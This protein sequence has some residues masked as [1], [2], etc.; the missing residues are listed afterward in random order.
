[1]RPRSTGVRPRSTSVRPR[2]TSVRPRSTGNRTGRARPARP[3]RRGWQARRAGGGRRCGPRRCRRSGRRRRTGRCRHLTGRAARDQPRST[4]S[5]R[6][7]TLCCRPRRGRRARRCLHGSERGRLIGC[8]CSR[9]DGSGRVR[10]AGLIDLERGG[11]SR[12]L[13]SGT[14]GRRSGRAARCRVLRRAPFSSRRLFGLLGLPLATQALAVRLATHPVG[15]SVLDGRRVA[16]HSDPEG[17]A[18]VERLLVAQ[19]ELAGELV[20]ADLLRHRLLRSFCSVTCRAME[21]TRY[22]ILAHCDPTLASRTPPAE[23]HGQSGR[24]T[25]RGHASQRPV[26]RPSPL[27]EIKARPATATQPRAATRASLAR[28]QLAIDEDDA[29]ELL[30]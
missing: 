2:S 30:D 25:S 7:G 5:S 26:E 22:T 9:H 19:T 18:E 16:L 1:M 14:L 8:C 4:W 20:H 24:R 27:G 29:G 13:G 10:S 11:C 12:L 3:L 15:L 23:L 6:R 21:A 17:H 28:H